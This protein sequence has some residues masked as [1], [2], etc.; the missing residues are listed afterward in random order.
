MAPTTQSARPVL[1]LVV[2]RL[3]HLVFRDC[4]LS[5]LGIRGL[6]RLAFEEITGRAPLDG[7]IQEVIQGLWEHWHQKFDKPTCSWMREGSRR[8][9][10]EDMLPGQENAI[11]AL[12]DADLP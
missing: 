7:E 2:E 10:T 12:E 9:I 8:R 4:R 1:I 6:A 3:H 11:R 5:Q